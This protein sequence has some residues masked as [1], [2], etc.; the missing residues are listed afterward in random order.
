MD[1]K[2]KDKQKKNEKYRQMIHFILKK[3]TQKTIIGI[4]SYNTTFLLVNLSINSL[5]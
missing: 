3:K 5:F 1:R 4:V 2:K